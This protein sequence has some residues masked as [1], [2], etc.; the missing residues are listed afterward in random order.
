MN[1][2]FVQDIVHNYEWYME[3]SNE[4]LL[5]VNFP[6]RKGKE[7]LKHIESVQQRKNDLHYKKILKT[8]EL[9]KKGE[10]AQIMED[11]KF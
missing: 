9:N 2:S 10:V 11:I 6:S 3:N 4:I 7:F 1:P 5:N 8:I